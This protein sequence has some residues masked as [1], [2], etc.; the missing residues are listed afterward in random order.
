MPVH[1]AKS[2]GADSILPVYSTRSSSRT[3]A[4]RIMAWTSIGSASVGVA[5]MY[6]GVLTGKTTCV[7]KVILN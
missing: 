5:V 4:L 2:A 1:W 3:K 7:R 6:I